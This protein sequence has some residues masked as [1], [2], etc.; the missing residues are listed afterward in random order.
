MNKSTGFKEL[1]FSKALF[2]WPVISFSAPYLYSYHHQ[3]EQILADHTSGCT[4][5]LTFLKIFSAVIV[6]FCFLIQLSLF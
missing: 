2:I 3:L 5:F 6:L 4:E 1:T